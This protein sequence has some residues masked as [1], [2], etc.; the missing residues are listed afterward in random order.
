MNDEIELLQGVV[1]VGEY[2]AWEPDKP[3]AFAVVRVVAIEGEWIR[4]E[5]V[6]TG[7][8]HWNEISRFREACWRLS[9]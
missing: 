8:K 9:R 5:D 1:R 3:H 7:M 2:Y 6:A 4:T